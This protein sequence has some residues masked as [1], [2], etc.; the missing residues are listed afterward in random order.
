MAVKPA[1][2]YRDLPRGAVDTYGEYVERAMTAAE[3]GQCNGANALLARGQIMRKKM[4]DRFQSV[5]ARESL[6]TLARAER[7]AA[8][9][10]RSMCA[11]HFN[12]RF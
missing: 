8:R 6:R 3:R 7:E 4:V 11:Q 1:K 2:K 12:G 10:V 5:R 9:V